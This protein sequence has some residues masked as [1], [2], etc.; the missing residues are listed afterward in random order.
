MENLLYYPY[1]NVPREDWT[2]RT[3][4]YYDTIGSIVPREYFFEPERN[5]HPFML[6]L[7]RSELV[8]PIDPINTLD[9]PWEVAMPFIE[10]IESNEFNQIQRRNSFHR[11]HYGRINRQKFEGDGAKI[12]SD[13]FNGEIFYT[14][15]QMGLARRTLDNWYVVEAVTANYLMTFL[16]NI[17]GEK[18]GYR[19][20]T[21][22]VRPSFSIAG[23]QKNENKEFDKRN[24]ILEELIPFPLDIDLKKLR[25]FKDKYLTELKAFKNKAEQIVLDSS[26]SMDSDLFKVKVEELK[27][28]KDELS[29]RMKENRFSQIIFGTVCGIAGAT[30]GLSTS[31]TTSAFLMGL[32]GF[33]SAIN[34]AVKLENPEKILD[35]SGMKY[36]AL[37][38]KKLIKTSR[39]HFV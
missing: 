8:R 28:R 30:Y 10:F 15:E 32:P 25:N 4:L 21:D 22:T 9:Q 35:Q 33:A 13:K 1:I 27:I 23:R 5:Y 2:L 14:L 37:A 20:T 18:L 3:L 6:E 24:R 39:Q 26:L 19:L 7:V 11:G 34:S 12:H 16:A 31:S 36:L 17:I 38:E 29:A